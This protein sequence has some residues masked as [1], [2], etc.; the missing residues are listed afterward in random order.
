MNNLRKILPLL[1]IALVII[2]G[3]TQATFMVYQSQAAMVLQLGKAVGEI[4]GPG[5]HFKIP[6]AQNVLYFDKRILEYD[7]PPSEVLTSDKKTLV[8]DNYIKWRITDPLM[9]YRTV[10]TI[11]GAQNRLDDI[12]YSQLRVSLGRHTLTEIV[13]SDRPKIMAQVTE[14]ASKLIN[15]YGIE[16]VDVRIKRTDLPEQNERS[17][18]GRMRGRTGTAGQ[19]VP[20][21]RRRGGG[22]DQI[23]REQGKG[24]H[25]GRGQAQV[26]SD[27]RRGR[28]PGHEDI[29]P[30]PET[31]ARVLRLQAQPGGLCEKPEKKFAADHHP[32]QP[33]L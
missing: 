23:R 14:R 11:P 12:I 30:G 21:R 7:A 33:L 4:R 15:E 24:R 10:R 6:F 29:R 18:F 16:V 32:G 1:A 22:Q 9:F 20:F 5:L 8:V 3:L 19:T 17:I 28:R 13:A 25:P 26:G 27:P 2:V 31:V